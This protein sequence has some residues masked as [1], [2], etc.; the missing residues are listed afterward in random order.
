MHSIESRFNYQLKKDN[1]DI[2]HGAYIHLAG[3]IWGK[4]VS[5]K[6]LT[7]LFKK[8]IPNDEYVNSDTKI[9]IRHLGILTN[10]T[11]VEQIV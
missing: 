2:K 8:L 4:R 11:E 1:G 5:R 6:D 7:R 9:L 10:L 3:V